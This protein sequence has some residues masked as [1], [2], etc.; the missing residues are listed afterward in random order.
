VRLIARGPDQHAVG[1]YL[2]ALAAALR[3]AAPAGV[4]LLGPAP[5]PVLKIRNL[6]RYHLRLRAATPRPLQ[7]LLHTVPATLPPPH[8]IELAVDVDPVSLL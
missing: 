6:Y 3:Q 4:Q 8:G 1:D 7:V 2:E 5:A